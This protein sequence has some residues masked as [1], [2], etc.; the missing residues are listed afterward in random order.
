MA[1]PTSEQYVRGMALEK[2]TRFA[3]SSPRYWEA[4]ENV[5]LA[6][7]FADDLRNGKQEDE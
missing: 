6:V 2:A 7:Y 4:F 1:L 3:A 5:D